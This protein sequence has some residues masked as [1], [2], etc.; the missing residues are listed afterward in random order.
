MIALAIR[1]DISKRRLTERLAWPGAAE[2]TSPSMFASFLVRFG[3]YPPAC[4][5][6]PGSLVHSTR[7]V[8]GREMRFN[9]RHSFGNVELKCWLIPKA[10]LG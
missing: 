8:G 9:A 2:A 10:V 5:P 6:E 4:L 3:K 1:K 7:L